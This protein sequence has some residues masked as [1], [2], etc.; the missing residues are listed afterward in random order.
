MDRQAASEKG[1]Q[2]TMSADTAQTIVANVIMLVGFAWLIGFAMGERSE[3]KLHDKIDRIREGGADD[4][5]A[6]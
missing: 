6:G 1:A 3:R 2:G 4:E 5:N